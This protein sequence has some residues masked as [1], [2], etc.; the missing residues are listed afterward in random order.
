MR[1]I[2]RSNGI[3]R[4]GSLVLLALLAPE[5]LLAASAPTYTLGGTVGGL[6]GSVELAVAITAPGTAQKSLGYSFST[7]T[8]FTL[9]PGLAKG[10]KYALAIYNEPVVQSCSIANASGTLEANVTNLKVSCITNEK[11]TVGGT[12]SGLSGSLTLLMNGANA[13]GVTKSGSFAFAP[14]LYPRAPYS[15]TV[16]TQPA[17]VQCQVAQG[18]GTL[19]AANIVSV[20]VTCSPKQVPS[21]KG[22]AVLPNGANG[23][24][25]VHLEDTTGKLLLSPAVTNLSAGGA[26]ISLISET[27]DFSQGIA[28]G[29][30]RLQS[31]NNATGAASVTQNLALPANAGEVTSVSVIPKT[32]LAMVAASSL[33]SYALASF[34]GGLHFTAN[35]GYRAGSASE[36]AVLASPNGSAAVATNT[37]GAVDFYSFSPATNA[38]PEGLVLQKAV[39]GGIGIPAVIGRGAMAWSPNSTIALIGDAGG[40][41]TVVENSDAFGGSAAPVATT[42]LIPGKAA[43]VSIAYAPNGEYAVLAT[44]AGLFTVTIQSGSTLSLKGPV[45][46]TYSTASGASF[47]LNHAQSVA[48]TSDGQYLVALTDQ[49]SESD[50]S[51]VIM[52]LDASGNVGNVE[53]GVSGFQANLGVDAL[54]V[55]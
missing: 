32:G 34:S 37:S 13:M 53:T 11:H 15:V 19:G 36:L 46:P 27:A 47:A 45:S 9:Q 44:S 51:L 35:Q 40:T 24:A 14:G 55:N 17:T 7:N 21:A 49:P 54:Y 41:V 33:T 20:I 12:V 5:L 31:L 38:Q 2:L 6:S 39:A 16:G 26:S 30:G 48:I 18:S 22:I 23:I 29:G 28:V 3:A 43:V 42:Y 10:S 4:A 1:H 52:P 8:A 25:I 50:G